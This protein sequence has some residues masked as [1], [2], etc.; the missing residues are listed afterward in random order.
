MSKRIVTEIWIY[1]IKSLGGFRVR[2]SS[3]MEKGLRH[4]RRWML[5]DESGNF[6]TQRVFPS[7]ALFK[8]HF[9]GQAIVV[10]YEHEQLELLQELPAHGKTISAKIWNDTVAVVEAS[11]YYH[12]WFSARL[13]M[14]CRLV[15]F[16]ESEP[17]L[18]DPAFRPDRENVSL[19]D[20]Y[21]LL[22]IGQS[23]LDD[24]NSRLEEPVP[25][26]RFRPNIVFTGGEPY[27]E[28][29]WRQFRVG[30]NR[31]LGVKPCGR[32][33]LTTVDQDT[34]VAGKEPLLTLSR[35][36]RINDRICFGQNVIPVDYHEVHEGDEIFLD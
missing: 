21:P 14:K 12:D 24:L 29:L 11:K 20:G 1:P 30:L 5:V 25:M 33:V 3:V 17:R 36:R 22:V 6:L 2:G 4:D 28:D 32:C 10:S 26:N 7:M 19:A 34:G 31:F 13:G 8:L 35:Y 27:E 9:N 18:I 15:G 16:P 23:S